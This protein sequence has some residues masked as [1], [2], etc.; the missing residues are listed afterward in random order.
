MTPSEFIIF[1]DNV[2][3]RHGKKHPNPVVQ[4]FVK[5]TGLENQPNQGWMSVT[6]SRRLRG[7]DQYTYAKSQKLIGNEKY[8]SR[9]H[10]GQ[11]PRESWN[12]E[13]AKCGYS[14]SVTAQKLYPALTKLNQI[15]LDRIGL[16]RLSK[17]LEQTG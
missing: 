14:V 6:K 8:D 1:C 11:P 13:C 10:R 12:F 4:G 2:S 7:N 16:T 5:Q 15:G 17:G 9:K 3:G